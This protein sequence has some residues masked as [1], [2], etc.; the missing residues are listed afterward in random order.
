[1]NRDD[2][3][4]VVQLTL[5]VMREAHIDPASD[6]GAAAFPVI[7]S[8]LLP[9]PTPVATGGEELSGPPI[10]IPR[11]GSDETVEAPAKPLE[12][13]AAW[14]NVGPARLGDLVEFD[15]E[16]L[17]IHLASHRLPSSRAERQRV[18]AYA[19]LGLARIGLQRED[20]E[21]TSLNDVIDAYGTLDQN[22]WANLQGATG[23]FG[24]RGQR[25]S[26][27]YRLTLPG[28][29]KAREIILEHLSAD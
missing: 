4:T 2:T 21:S 20:V 22:V 29:D 10:R 1:M 19:Y 28:L 18:L 27:T 26:Y 7:L 24:R 15:D 17:V 14:L 8:A 12:R 6:L 5:E 9:A 11:A 16:S 13:A 23:S 3:L 25:G